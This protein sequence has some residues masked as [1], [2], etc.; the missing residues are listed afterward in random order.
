MQIVIYEFTIYEFLLTAFYLFYFMLD[1][2]I[3]IT[4]SLLVYVKT[5]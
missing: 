4:L 5:V 2:Q 1:W 3:Y